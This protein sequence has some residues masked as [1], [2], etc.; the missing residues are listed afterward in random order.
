MELQSESLPETDTTDTSV[1]S[2]AAAAA[3][4]PTGISQQCV[5]TFNKTVLEF[6]NE[7]KA[8]FP[9]LEDIVNEVCIA[10]RFR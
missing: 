7:L 1:S 3:A 6:V 5:G 9:E 8:T 4:A 10:F 2:A